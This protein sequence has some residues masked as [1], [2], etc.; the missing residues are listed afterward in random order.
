MPRQQGLRVRPRRPSDGDPDGVSPVGTGADA[1]EDTGLDAGWAT[2]DPQPGTDDVTVLQ[3][4]G[5]ARAGAGAPPAAAG[6][7]GGETGGETAGPA[8]RRLPSIATVLVAVG[9]LAAGA[10]AGTGYGEHAE[11]Q[12]AAAATT[13]LLWSD[14][15]QLPADDTSTDELSA[16]PDR[17][18]VTATVSGT[19]VI[20]ERVLL[21]AGT[22]D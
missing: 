17:L 5:P 13:V 15:G 21:G 2:H 8:R 1:A 11:R 19:P 10:V 22:A 6:E 20:L 7:T 9:C 14:P 12:Q 3:L 18:R 4:D 16:T